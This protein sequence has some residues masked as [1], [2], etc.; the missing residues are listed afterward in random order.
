MH[1][2]RVI[3]LCLAAIGLCPAQQP[4]PPAP[5]LPSDPRAILEAARP[6]YDFTSDQLKPW[7]LKVSYQM[8]DDK[9]HP[10]EQGTF[11]YWWAS[12]EV[13]RSSWTRGAMSYSGGTW[14]S[15]A[16]HIWAPAKR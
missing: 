16:A 12:P 11:E 15:A 9:E 2:A 5:G 1:S 8:Y 3:A 14:Q 7:H 10:T 13:Y 4:A 6:F